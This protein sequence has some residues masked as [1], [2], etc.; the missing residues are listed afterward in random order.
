[1]ADKPLVTYCNNA[2]HPHPTSIA[3][4][5]CDLVAHRQRVLERERAETEARRRKEGK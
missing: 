3:A 2:G 5:E 1:M 4:R